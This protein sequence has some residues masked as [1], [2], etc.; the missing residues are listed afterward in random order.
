M[1]ICTPLVVSIIPA[2]VTYRY[3]SQENSFNCSITALNLVTTVMR[4]DLK[5][6]LTKIYFNDQKGHDAQA[7]EQCE[8]IM[9][10]SESNKEKVQLYQH[11]G[12]MRVNKGES[13]DITVRAQ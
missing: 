13:Y 1:S 6:N 5:K 9:R 2:M 3:R 12:T 11:N 10:D 7:K 4:P 8:S